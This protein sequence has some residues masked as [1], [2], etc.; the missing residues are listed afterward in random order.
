ME[1]RVTTERVRRMQF[2][3]EY[4]GS[5]PGPVMRV[6][7]EAAARGVPLDDIR[8]MN[9]NRDLRLRGNRPEIRKSRLF[10]WTMR[11]LSAAFDLMLA[12]HFLLMCVLTVL[13]HGPIGLKVVVLCAVTLIYSVLYRG[14]ALYTS[15]AHG[16]LSRSGDLVAAVSE[17]VPSTHKA[18]TILE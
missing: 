15:R 13:V 5:A 11:I 17:E 18:R 7:R 1:A 14:W 16:A 8:L 2:A 6:A 9:L 4:W 3:V 10:Q 12:T